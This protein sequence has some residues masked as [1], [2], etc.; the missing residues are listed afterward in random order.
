M[1]KIVFICDGNTCRSP[2]AEGLFKKMVKNAD[3]SSAGFANAS[4]GVL[5]VGVDD[6]GKL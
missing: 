1:K 2:M 5:Y 3:I 6:S 4:G